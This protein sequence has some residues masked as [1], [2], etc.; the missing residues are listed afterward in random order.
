M[1]ADQVPCGADVG[2]VVDAVREVIDAGVDHVY[3][4]QIGDDQETFLEAWS[5]AIAPE[6][7]TA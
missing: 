2:A 7:G 5:T 4:H 6:L 3:V 1:I